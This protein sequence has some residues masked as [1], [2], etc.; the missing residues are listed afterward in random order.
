MK[1]DEEIDFIARHY[2]RG[3]FASRSALERI[4]PGR[5][6]RL[7]TVRIAAAAALLIA[8]G[9]AAAL[10]ITHSSSTDRAAE[11]VPHDAPTAV[12][13]DIKV[14][15]FESTPLTVVADK[16]REVYG[17]SVRNLPDDA[18][19]ITLSLHYEGSAADLV[20][21]INEIL[22]TQMTIEE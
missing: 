1:H 13:D 4:M 6:S 17:V 5:M 15:D 8:A 16:I 7:R 19:D 3:A 2:R 22:S 18:G 21:T 20:D 12:A 14:I 11:T 10:L 9:T